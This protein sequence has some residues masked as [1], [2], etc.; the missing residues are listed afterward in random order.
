[1]KF[2]QPREYSK[3]EENW[4]AIL[5]WAKNALMLRTKVTTVIIG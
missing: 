1:M 3:E 5:K 2:N 4:E